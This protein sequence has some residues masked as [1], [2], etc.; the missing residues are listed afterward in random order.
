MKRASKGLFPPLVEVKPKVRD[1]RAAP[2]T[3][4]KALAETDSGPWGEA[5]TRTTPR[6][7]R[8]FR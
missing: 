4:G 8:V 1:R 7:N 6:E 5:A 3:A 2:E